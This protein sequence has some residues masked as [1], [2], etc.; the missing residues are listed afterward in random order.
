MDLA[1]KTGQ[2]M[3][4]QH[5]DNLVLDIR[6]SGCAHWEGRTHCDS[7]LVGGL[8][9]YLAGSVGSPKKQTVCVSGILFPAQA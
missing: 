7:R 4:S 6:E 8:R 3:C 5:D 1:T 2:F 9:K